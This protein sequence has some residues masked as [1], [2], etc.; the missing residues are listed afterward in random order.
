MSRTNRWDLL[1]DGV[2]KKVPV[3]WSELGAIASHGGR[4]YWVYHDR[5]GLPHIDT[6]KP[7]PPR[8]RWEL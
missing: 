8:E 6:S 7:I 1:V 4:R 2:Q 5:G 3:R